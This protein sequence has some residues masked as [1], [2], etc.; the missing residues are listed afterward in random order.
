MNDKILSDADEYNKKMEIE[1]TKM[2]LYIKST[3]NFYLLIM[4]TY[5]Q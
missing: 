4:C 5:K 2:F 1:A 3:Y